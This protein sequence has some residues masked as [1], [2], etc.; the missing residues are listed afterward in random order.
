MVADEGL[1]ADVA[2]RLARTLPESLA[3][4]FPDRSEWEVEV[5]CEALPLLGTGKIPIFGRTD[6]LTRDHRWDMVVFLTELPRWSG[7]EPLAFETFGERRIALVSMPAMGWFGL[8]RR[9]RQV[10][11]EVVEAVLDLSSSGHTS[12]EAG[13]TSADEPTGPGL[14]L[15]NVRG[16][17][18]LLFGMVRHNRPWR[19]V[20]SLDRPIA[21]A[22][23]TAAFPIFYSSIWGMAEALSVLRLAVVSA[24]AVLVMVGWLI[25]HNGLWERRSSD[26]HVGRVGLY[27]ASTFVTIVIGVACMYALLVIIA[28][29]AAVAVIPS[30]YMSETL[31]Q[32]AGVVEYLKLAWLASS[33]GT[34]AGALGSSFETES[35][36]RQATYSKREHERW[37][38]DQARG[39]NG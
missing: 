35:A 31:R 32:P 10:I 23:G 34:V 24:F 16:R 33:M 19:L 29:L 26:D 3:E 39:D 22:V 9:A 5:E 20:P 7:E 17:L 36:V 11:V 21:A 6:E 18:R 4:H 14:I 38:R 13:D 12:E 28:L 25:V 15:P 30:S 37:E 1:P 2:Q 8:C 27:N